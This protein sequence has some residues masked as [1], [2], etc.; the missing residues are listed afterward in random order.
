MTDTEQVCAICKKSLTGRHEHIIESC[1]INDGAPLSFIIDMQ[2]WY[3]KP[4]AHARQL[5][6]ARAELKEFFPGKEFEIQPVRTMVRSEEK[7]SALVGVSYVA[8]YAVYEK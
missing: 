2:R 5:A 7:I 8:T 4:T 3:D 6:T 1:V